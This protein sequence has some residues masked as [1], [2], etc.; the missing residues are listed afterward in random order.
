MAFALLMS[1]RQFGIDIGLMTLSRHSRELHQRT[2]EALTAVAS[3]TTP[4]ATF[5]AITQ[6][7]MLLGEEAEH[8]WPLIECLAQRQGEMAHL[9]RLADTDE[10]T[11]AGNRRAFEDALKRELARRARTGDE[12]S[13]L[14]V[15]M[16]DLKLRNDTLGHS[17]GDHALRTM[18]QLCMAE[19]RTTDVVARIGGDEFAIVLVGSDA[20][21]ASAFVERLRQSIEMTYVAD[22]ALRASIG[23]AVASDSLCTASELLAAA[24]RNMYADKTRRKAGR[25]SRRSFQPPRREEAALRGR[26]LEGQSETVA[27]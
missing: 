10:L 22:I 9:R 3:A 16:D 5:R 7:K 24:D 14:V 13:V 23:L 18:A 12:M 11:G 26:E 8:Y 20:A 21:G 4:L 17:S 2:V 19:V 15:D 27:A 1:M 25:E 6:A